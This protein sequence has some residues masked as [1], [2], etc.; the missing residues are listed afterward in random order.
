MFTGRIGQADFW[1]VYLP[2]ILFLALSGPYN[3]FASGFI[4]NMEAHGSRSFI[5][6][7]LTTGIIINS[8][9]VIVLFVGLGIIVRRLHDINLSGWVLIA[10]WVI[11]APL[12]YYLLLHFTYFYHYFDLVSTII[13]TCLLGL[14]IGGREPNKYGNAI[15]YRS[16]WAAFVG[17]KINSKLL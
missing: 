15:R 8:L 14:W 16:W 2:T 4:H 5:L 11:T 3:F 7:T 13:I 10:W 9:F 6:M 12:D 17:D 1:K